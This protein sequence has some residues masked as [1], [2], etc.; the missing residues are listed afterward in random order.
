MS[1]TY[2]GAMT[3]HVMFVISG[4]ERG[5]AENQLVGTA[6]ALSTR[7]WNVTVLS[8]LPFS[9]NSWATD[10]ENTGVSLLTLNASSGF[11]KYFSLVDVLRHIRRLKPDILVGFMFHGIMAVRVAGLLAG[12][13]ANVSSIHS[14]RHSTFRE[15]VM[16]ATDRLTDAVTVLSRHLASELTCRRVASLSHIHVIPNSV[17]IARFETGLCRSTTRE[18]MGVTE[19]QF[20]WLAAGRLDDAKDYPNLLEAFSVLYRQHPD[21]RLLIAGDGPLKSRLNA[22]IQHLGMDGRVRLLG[23]RL[24]MPA[25]YAA[26]DALVLSSEWEGMPNVVLEAM[27]SGRPVVSTSVG[28]VPEIIADG[29]SGLIVPPHDHKALAGSMERMMDLPEKTRK[30]F[31]RAGYEHVRREF[32]QEK[33]I[34]KWEDLFERLLRAKSEDMEQRSVE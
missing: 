5:G 11:R 9:N 29:E 3:R 8:F 21:A 23:L 34:D 7:G 33:V 19:H 31:G 2:S 17:N 15:F 30:A 14:D 28:A 32:S 26:S 6:A 1:R 4:L 10:L 25:L 12:E 16:R 13:R 27:A 24:D 22:M 20:L 18:Q